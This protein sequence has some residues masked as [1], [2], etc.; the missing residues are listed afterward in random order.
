MRLSALLLAAACLPGGH[1]RAAELEILFPDMAPAILRKPDTGEVGGVVAERVRAIAGR[2]GIDLVWNGPVPRARIVAELETRPACTVNAIRTPE[3]AARFLFTEPI[4]APR[5]VAVITRSDPPWKTPPAS[6]AALLADRA[7]VLGQM[8][9]ASHGEAIDRMIA[10]AG[11]PTQAFRGTPEDLLQLVAAGR[12]DYALGDLRDDRQL[13]EMM[14]ATRL[15]PGRLRVLHF[16]D[17]PA[18][19]PGR[20]M[21]SHAVGGGVISTL[22]KAI[23]A[24]GKDTSPP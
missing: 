13:A 1:A 16:P 12:V 17:L 14:A 4:F 9:G 22:D 2:A 8:L 23:A 10:Q 20:I 6:F 11:T 24:L 7:L 15:E 19:E 3:R 21:C 18:Q 5:R